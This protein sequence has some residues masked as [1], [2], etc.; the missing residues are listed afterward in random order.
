MTFHPMKPV[1]WKAAAA[2][3]QLCE[4]TPG[5]YGDVVAAFERTLLLL[6]D[7]TAAPTGFKDCYE[8]LGEFEKITA[9]LIQF[10]EM[11]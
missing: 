7:T 5:D 8:L 1:F 4:M 10:G 11:G 9:F 3:H 6:P 2:F